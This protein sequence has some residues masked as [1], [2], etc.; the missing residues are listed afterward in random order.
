MLVEVRTIDELRAVLD[1]LWPGRRAGLPQ[2]AYA[3]LFAASE[4]KADRGGL[5]WQ[6]ARMVQCSMSHDPE[7]KTVWFEKWLPPDAA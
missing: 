6:F 1:G 5:A 4:P 2:E 3:G 7:A